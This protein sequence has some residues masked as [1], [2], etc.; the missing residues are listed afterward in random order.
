MLSAVD[1]YLFGAIGLVLGL[2]IAFLLKA[3]PLKILFWSVFYVYII[4]VLGLTLF[5]I[6]YQGAEL[7]DSVPNNFIP[8]RTII[9]TLQMGLTVTAFIQ[10]AGNILIA[11]PYGVVLDL[12]MRKSNKIWLFLFPLLFPLVIES[13]QFIIGFAIGYNYRSVDIDDFIL[14]A[15]GGYL[16]ILFSKLLLKN[17]GYKNL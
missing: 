11:A 9:S 12:T 10:I 4:V 15:L 14:N 13:L 2:V 1:L 3:K 8:F 5:P 7:F 6:P 16:G 17:Y